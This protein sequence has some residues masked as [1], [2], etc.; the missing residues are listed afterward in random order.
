[1]VT[2]VDLGAAVDVYLKQVVPL[3]PSDYQNASRDASGARIGRYRLIGRLAKGGMAEA[4]LALS[5]EVPG[6]RTLVVVK[7]ILP[8]LATNEQFVRM[9]LDEARIGALLDHPNIPRIIEVGH[10]EDGYFLAMEA[11]PG[12]TLSAILRRAARR[13]RPLGQADAAFIVGRAAAALGYA[14]AHT[15]A[16]GRPLNIVHRDVSPENILVSFEG[17]VKVI[18]FG[19]AS[20]HGRLS[21]T[22]VGGLK[23]KVEYMSPEQASG[24]PVDH[25]SDVFSLGVVLWEALSGRRLFRRETD[26]AVMRA[27]SNDP[28]PRPSG[29]RPIAPRLE[30]IV[31]TALERAPEDRFQ[32]AHEMALLLERHAFRTDGFDPAALVTQLKQL[33]PAD[34]AGW[35][36]TVGTAQAV[37]SSGRR[38]ITA[39]FPLLGGEGTRTG[40]PTLALHP[41]PRSKA[42]TRVERA[43]IVR[44]FPAES[45]SGLDIDDHPPLPRLTS[46][47][48]AQP[49]PGTDDG[50]LPSGPGDD[51]AAYAALR[52]WALRRARRPRPIWLLVGAIAAAAVFAGLRWRA[53]VPGAPAPIVDVRDEAAAAE[54]R[55]VVEPLQSVSGSPSP[56]AAPGGSEGAAAAATEAPPAPAALA[57]LG[58]PVPAAMPE[59]PSAVA[60]PAAPRP[61]LRRSPAGPVRVVKKTV[62]K[63]AIAH[64]AAAAAKPA[65]PRPS[66][67]SSEKRPTQAPRVRPGWRDPFQ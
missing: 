61:A 38:H 25:R 35:K 9:F 21:E 15:D 14:H 30:E 8:D 65:P 39:A 42:T 37:E 49:D 2:A 31:M 57:P 59:P 11:V 18:D 19:I 41:K 13:E 40:G 20:A 28:I 29:P 54:L 22:H 52:R 33:F 58:A 17:A 44:T 12:K 34:H 6:L 67:G 23:G 63:H 36:A 43:E 26:L 60:V 46:W 3:T 55:P 53:G 66:A 27:I 64:R 45:S 50:E 48:D 5:G 47:G 4:F 51:A 1:M 10:D 56:A 32:D 7:R 24:A 16:D 62:R